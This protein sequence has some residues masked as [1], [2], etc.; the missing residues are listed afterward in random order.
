[1]GLPAGVAVK[2]IRFQ[3]KDISDVGL[4]VAAHGDV[5]D[6]DIELSTHATLFSGYAINAK[7]ERVLDYWVVVFARDRRLWDLP[8]SRFRQIVRA[9]QEGRFAVVGLPAGDY[10]AVALDYI[11]RDEVIM[12]ELFERLFEKATQISLDDVTPT[13]VELKLFVSP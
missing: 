7:R 6:V 4:D 10:M 5:K 9:D 8:F 3:G 11:D 1:M 13:T 2:S 12:P